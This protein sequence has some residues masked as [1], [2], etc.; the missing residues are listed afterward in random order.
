MRLFYSIILFSFCFSCI[1]VRIAPNMK[2]GKVVKAKR[3]VKNLPGQN[4][5]VFDDPK[6]ANDFYNYINA[7]Y[8]I[9]YDDI[10]GNVPVTIAEKKL[11]L[12]LYEVNKETKTVNL[13]PIIVD[14]GLEENGYS[15][16]LESAEVTRLG[17]WYIALTVTDEDF[18]DGLNEDYKIYKEVESYVMN[19]RKEYLSTTHYIE[20]FLKAK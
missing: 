6:D 14:A 12:T 20:V 7:K 15:P 2:E 11:F 4:T 13:I 3:F 1:P 19:L 16:I 10:D 8:Q 17:K 18:N 9:S 5:Y